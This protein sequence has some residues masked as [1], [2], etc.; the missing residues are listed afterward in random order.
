MISIDIELSAWF[1][2]EGVET[3]LFMG[4]SGE[5]IAEN[6]EPYEKLVDQTIDSMLLMDKLATYHQEDAEDLVTA[7]ENLAKHAR[8]RVD[9][10]KSW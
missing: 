5:P 7:L 6:L 2:P 4:N 1:T 3:S 8:E 10:L 9:A